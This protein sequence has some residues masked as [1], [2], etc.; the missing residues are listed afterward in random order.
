MSGG[1]DDIT[2][3]IGKDEDVF[4]LYFVEGFDSI[5]WSTQFQFPQSSFV[6]ITIPDLDA[7]GIMVPGETV[8]N[9]DLVPVTRGCRVTNTVRRMETN[10]WR[11]ETFSAGGGISDDLKVIV[12]VLHDDSFDHFIGFN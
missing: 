10:H 8:W 4:V 9:G 5:L 1:A 7:G 2:E 11:D 12:S 6:D 3:M